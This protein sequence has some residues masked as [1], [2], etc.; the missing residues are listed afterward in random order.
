M[1]W[2]RNSEHSMGGLRWLEKVAELHD[3]WVKIANLYP[4]DDYAEDIVQES[5]I[6][7]YKYANESKIIDANGNVRKGYMFFT[8]RSLCLQYINKKRKIEKV[9]ISTCFNIAEEITIEEKEA[10]EYICDKVDTLLKDVH[11]YDE[12]L[13]KVYRDSGL[14]MRKLAKETNTSLVTIFTSLKETK[15]YIFENLY[16]D[17]FDFKNGD[18][19]LN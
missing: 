18:Y 9:D 5:Y 11:F 12:R 2:I 8:V 19:E 6:A 13:F 15:R 3:E 7:L 14:S 10:F 17:W 4:V 1:H 16:E